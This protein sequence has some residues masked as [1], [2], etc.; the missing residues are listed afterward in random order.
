MI[1]YGSGYFTGLKLGFILIVLSIEFY[2]LIFEKFIEKEIVFQEILIFSFLFFISIVIVVWKISLISILIPPAGFIII[3]FLKKREEDV[4]TITEEEK[5]IEKLKKIVEQQPNNFKAYEELGDIYF[6]REDYENALNLYITSYK[7]KDFPYIKK[8]IEITKR[9]LEIKK[10][11]IWI[12]RNCGEDNLKEN[13]KCKNCGEE[14]EVLKSII[15]DLKKLKKHF[16]IFFIS[17]LIILLGFYIYYI[18]PLY[19]SIC[20]F[21]LLFYFLIKFFLIN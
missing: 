7:L 10:G 3:H 5:R 19:L 17:P 13:Q 9:L 1:D 2:Y 14:K 21:L 18:L 6:K 20:L 4:L 12:C 8:K 15:T 11:N 16:L